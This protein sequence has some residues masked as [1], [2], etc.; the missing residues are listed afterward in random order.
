[1]GVGGRER[2]F[3]FNV[4]TAY[5]QHAE[6]FRRAFRRLQPLAPGKEERFLLLFPGWQATNTLRVVGRETITIPAGTFDTWRFRLSHDG[7]PWFAGEVDLWMSDAGMRVK[8][9]GRLIRG[10]AARDG[11]GGV[12]LTRWEAVSVTVP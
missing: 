6:D 3:V 7:G 9:E 1:M 12:F 11:P 10:T 5:D 2:A 4:W 8:Q